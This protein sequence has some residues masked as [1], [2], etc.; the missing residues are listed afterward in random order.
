MAKYTFTCEQCS[1]AVNFTVE[2]ENEDEAVEKLMEET[3]G[4]VGEKHPDM[5]NASPEE[6]KNMIKSSLKKED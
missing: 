1:P 3:K 4:H 5:A 2:A 6:A